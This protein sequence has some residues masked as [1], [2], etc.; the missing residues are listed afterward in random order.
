MAMRQALVALAGAL[1]GATPSAPLAGGVRAFA[2]QAPSVYD[3]MC[4]GCCAARRA[5]CQCRSRAAQLHARRPVPNAA[6]TAALSRSCRSVQLTVVDG[7][8]RRHVVRGLV[9]QNIVEVLEQ[10]MDTLGEEGKECAGRTA[11]QQRLLGGVP[12]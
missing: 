2:S 11:R 1:R 8:G 9:G 12:V 5:T 3:R 6:A 4:V 7:E 10:H